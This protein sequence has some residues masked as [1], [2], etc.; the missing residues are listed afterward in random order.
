M[1]KQALGEEGMSRT[2]LFCCTL[3]THRNVGTDP[4]NSIV[5][6]PLYITI[7]ILHIIRRLVYYSV[8]NASET[9]LSPS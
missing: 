5:P 7:T 2:H 9:G 3:E 4:P 8:H 1:F 6:R